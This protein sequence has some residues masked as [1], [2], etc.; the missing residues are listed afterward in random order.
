M[1][2][3]D[4]QPEDFVRVDGDV[5]HFRMPSGE[6][7]SV[8]LRSSPYARQVAARAL[9]ERSAAGRPLFDPGSS[10][11]PAQPAAPPPAP[12]PAPMS[13]PMVD[14]PMSQAAEPVAPTAAPPMPAPMSGPSGASNEDRVSDEEYLRRRFIGSIYQRDAEMI[15]QGLPTPSE[16]RINHGRRLLNMPPLPRPSREVVPFTAPAQPVPPAAGPQERTTEEGMRLRLAREAVG[17]LMAERSAQAPAEAPTLPVAPV[18]GAAPMQPS[19][20]PTAPAMAAPI[21]IR[22]EELPPTLDQ[23]MV[24]GGALPEERYQGMLAQLSG[25]TPAER[26]DAARRGLIDRAADLEARRA[27]AA[28]EAARQQAEAIDASEMRR[29]QI[30]RDRRIAMGDAQRSYVAAVERLGAMREDPARV[31]RSAGGAVSAAIAIGL[32]AAGAALAGGGENSALAIIQRN[33]DRDIAAQRTDLATAGNVAD[34]RRGILGIVSQEFSSREAAES[35]ARAAM[36]Q[37]AQAQA[38]RVTAGLDNEAARLRGEELQQQLSDQA[39]ASAAEAQRQEAEWRLNMALST[40]RL[41]RIQLRNATEARALAARAAGAGAGRAP[42]A[43]QMQAFN[44]YVESGADPR[45]AARIMRIAPE[46]VPASG[47]FAL[48]QRPEDRVELTP[49][50]METINRMLQSGATRAEVSQATGIPEEMVRQYASSQEDQS[51]GVLSALSDSL[52]RLDGLI[53]PEGSDIPGVGVFDSRIP[54]SAL[55]QVGRNI[56]VEIANITDLIGR[57]RSGGAISAEEMDRFMSIVRGAG[58]EADLRAGIAR[59]RAEVRSRMRRAPSGQSVAER[60]VS[61]AAQAPGF[62]GRRSE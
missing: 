34:A 52:D 51:G 48:G 11:Q 30:E 54:D 32:G 24:P 22:R 42:T 14:G 18:P 7:V 5:G 47:R 10:P 26:G 12:P 58:T 61:A 19:A 4:L 36:L 33:I 17:R 8:D 31:L 13:A 55:S 46:L 56:R 62:V 44:T 9:V 16:Q 20:Q 37:A 3:E 21:R 60:G 38:A 6:R 23:L 53:G 1:F 45:E 28:A 2:P 25:G 40:A 41:E 15:A 39:A 59:I 49:Q 35:A 29:Q 50:R 57:L 43:A 27:D